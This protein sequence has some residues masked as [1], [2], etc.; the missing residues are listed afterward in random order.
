MEEFKIGNTCTLTMT[1]D[2]M[3]LE[4]EREAF[5][6]MPNF[7]AEEITEEDGVFKPCWFL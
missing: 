4:S 2:W 7:L 3:G 1:K 6:M 5:R